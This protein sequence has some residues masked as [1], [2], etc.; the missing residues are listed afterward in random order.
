MVALRQFLILSDV[1][2]DI[3]EAGAFW[4]GEGVVRPGGGIQGAKKPP[5]ASLLG[6][7]VTSHSARRVSGADS[8]SS[9]ALQRCHPKNG[10]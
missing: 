8:H 1:A 3:F 2:M 6:P 7:H 5:R 10:E 4:D 9:R